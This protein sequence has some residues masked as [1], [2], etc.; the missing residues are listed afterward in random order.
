M[1]GSSEIDPAES[2]EYVPLLNR[3]V[4]AS[5]DSFCR[6]HKDLRLRTVFRGMTT[7]AHIALRIALL[8][9]QAA[10]GLADRYP[11]AGDDSHHP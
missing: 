10:Y 3:V 9:L 7:M 6:V 2:W 8:F 5:P 11:F 1:N 4:G